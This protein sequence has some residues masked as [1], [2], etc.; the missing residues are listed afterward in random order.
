MNADVELENDNSVRKRAFNLFKL[1]EE[2]SHDSVAVVTHKG[3]LR[4]LERGCFGI[5]GS[6]EF[7]NCEMRVYRIEMT[8]GNLF[9]DSVHRLR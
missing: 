4:A 2:S 6:P 5:S 9:L 8:P 7:K 3:F 1:L